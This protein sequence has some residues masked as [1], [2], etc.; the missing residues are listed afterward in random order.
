MDCSV[1]ASAVTPSEHL[2]P[3]LHS[4]GGGFEYRPGQRLSCLRSSV[5]LSAPLPQGNFQRRISRLP[6]SRNFSTLVIATTDI[7]RSGSCASAVRSPTGTDEQKHYR[8]SRRHLLVPFHRARLS[9]SHTLGYSVYCSKY[10]LRANFSCAYIC[11]I[12]YYATK[13]YREVDL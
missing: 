6:Y 1:G 9:A 3:D 8:L 10:Y 13:A 7:I 5:F 12:N 4:G 11:V 2:H